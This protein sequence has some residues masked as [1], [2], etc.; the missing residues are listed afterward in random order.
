M[1]IYTSY[2]ANMRNIPD[3]IIPISIAGEAP[4]WYNGLEYKKLAPKVGFFNEWKKNGLP[5][6]WYTSRFKHEV[7]RT[8]DA[9]SVFYELEQL[10]GGKD[11]VLLCYEKP[12]SFCHRHLV[13]EWLSSQ[14]DIIVYELGKDLKS[15][16][17]G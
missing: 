14:L 7:L 8:L 4:D 6:S 10:S 12:G 15:N 9:E 11:C 2:Y 3:N 1:R 16:T 13:S 17:R 5:N